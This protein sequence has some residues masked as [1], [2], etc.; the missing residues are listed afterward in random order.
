MIVSNVP[1][2]MHELCIDAGDSERYFL[3]NCAIFPPSI[4]RGL[5]TI[6]VTSYHGQ[7][8]VSAMVD[9]TEAFSDVAEKLMIG[10]YEAF[11]EFHQEALQRTF[12]H[13]C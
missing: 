2:P 9:A 13:D 7:V 8:Y 10:T 1:G 4:G 6:G 11:D 12:K 5:I 3:T